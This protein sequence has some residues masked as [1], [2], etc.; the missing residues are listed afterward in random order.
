MDLAWQL[1]TIGCVFTEGLIDL[2]PSSSHLIFQENFAQEFIMKIVLTLLLV[3]FVTR[4]VA[5]S[6]VCEL[7]GF[8]AHDTSGF[9]S[10]PI[11]E[12]IDGACIDNA[13]R[14]GFTADGEGCDGKKV[15]IALYT[16]DER[17]WRDDRQ[18]RVYPWALDG[19]IDGNIHGDARDDGEYSLSAVVKGSPHTLI[20]TKFELARDCDPSPE[21]CT[22]VNSVESLE[23]AISKATDAS[24]P[25]QIVLCPEPLMLSTEIDIS[26][27]SFDLVC[28]NIDAGGENCVISGGGVTRIFKGSPAKASFLGIDFIDGYEPVSQGGAM[29]L[30]GGLVLVDRCGFYNNVAATSAGAI[31]AAGPTV[32]LDIIDSTFFA[33]EATVSTSV[34]EKSVVVTYHSS[35][36]YPCLP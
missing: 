26:S 36:V 1:V 22:G 34:H 28:A 33:N 27:K 9:Q 24:N 18:E 32:V 8:T 10:E 2:P 23:E 31:R 25:T 12:V 14:I 30:T 20:T 15:Y 29:V 13:D 7:T 17:Y 35:R 4:A 21:P 5:N 19:D 11:G 3:S 16:E 6:D